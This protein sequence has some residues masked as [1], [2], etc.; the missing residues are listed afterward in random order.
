MAYVPPVAYTP[1][2]RRTTTTKDVTVKNII[3]KDTVL[4]LKELGENIKLS[5]LYVEHEEVESCVNKILEGNPKVRF[6]IIQYSRKDGKVYFY[7]DKELD[8]SKWRDRNKEVLD[9][10]VDNDKIS[11]ILNITL[12]KEDIP[13]NNIS[14]N[15]L[16]NIYEGKVKLLEGLIKKYE[17]VL[18]KI[19]NVDEVSLY[20]YI[21]S[22]EICLY[23]NKE[24]E[25]T[26]YTFNIVNDD[27]RLSEVSS[28][29]KI[30]D[31]L[32][33][34]GK[35][36][37]AFY[38]EYVEQYQDK[39]LKITDSYVIEIDPIWKSTYVYISGDSDFKISMNFGEKWKLSCNSLKV[40]EE[41][42]N[43]IEELLNKISVPLD[44]CPSFVAEE[45]E[46][47]E[48]E[49]QERIKQEKEALE[50]ERQRLLEEKM[51]QER[52]D[53]VIRKIFP[54]YKRKKQKK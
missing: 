29:N 34:V 49:R 44:C 11:R 17:K 41:F 16:T 52:K 21:Y 8:L 5:H 51:K 12:N 33:L 22:K 53:A 7:T 46:K 14:L 39:L 28:K 27:V 43:K 38:K 10:E 9:V 3:Y 18:T 48:L 26:K 31:I 15:K 24:F 40:Q 1:I 2:S 19:L 42:G 35:E 37:K 54:F 30:D 50:I 45:L 23:V 25:H 6:N 47:E 36:I 32:Y 13:E 4:D 20:C